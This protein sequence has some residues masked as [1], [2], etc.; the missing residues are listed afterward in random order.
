M[1]FILHA[2]D[3]IIIESVHDIFSQVE[4]MSVVYKARSTSIAFCF[5]NFDTRRARRVCL[6][7]G[8]KKSDMIAGRNVGA[9]V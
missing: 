2:I 8:R 9:S 6:Q 4:G 1:K 3:S 5:L 7:K